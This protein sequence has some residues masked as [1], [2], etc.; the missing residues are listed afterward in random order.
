MIMDG[1]T[2]YVEAIDG[3][4]AQQW[5]LANESDEY[6]PAFSPGG[7]WIASVSERTGSPE[8]FV[9]AYPERGPIHPI[10]TDDGTVPRWSGDDRELFDRSG[11]RMMAVTIDTEPEFKADLPRMLFQTDFEW[12]GFDVASDGRFLIMRA[13]DGQRRSQIRVIL[14]WAEEVKRLVPTGR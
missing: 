5:A 4:R 12:D 9:Q 1:G 8:I 6:R 10:S 13:P 11:R 7:E 2:V 14:N 3:T